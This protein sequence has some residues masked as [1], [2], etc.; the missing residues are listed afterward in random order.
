MN[1]EPLLTRGVIIAA[2]SA[3]ITLGLSFGWID[4]SDTQREAVLAVVGFMAPLLVVA[5]TRHLVTPLSDPR[6]AGG[7]NL[8]KKQ[9][10]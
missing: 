6:D 3:L 9:V 8:V 1:R 4:W 10:S 2:A 7:D 5:I